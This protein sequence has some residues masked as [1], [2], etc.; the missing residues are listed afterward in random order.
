MPSSTGSFQP[1][2]RTHFFKS[3][4]LAVGFFTT[5][6]PGKPTLLQYPLLNMN[7][8]DK[9]KRIH[10]SFKAI[11]HLSTPILVVM[12][13]IPNESHFGRLSQHRTKTYPK[14]YHC[15]QIPSLLSAPILLL[16]QCQLRT[17]SIHDLL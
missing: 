9:I 6:P 12:Q 14:P 15:I 10:L 7:F 5:E 11:G 1:R 3:P 2:D 17:S 16:L 4:V 13:F 8:Y